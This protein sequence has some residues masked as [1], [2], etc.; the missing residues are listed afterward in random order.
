MKTIRLDLSFIDQHSEE[1]FAC[2]C[3][4]TVPQD[5]DRY[6]VIVFVAKES[7]RGATAW[8][9]CSLRCLAFEAIKDGAV[10]PVLKPTLSKEST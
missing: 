8:R 1:A 7:G 9:F 3:G 5:G 2:S 6:L 4:K 10:D